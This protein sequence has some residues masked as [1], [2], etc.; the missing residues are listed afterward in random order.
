MGIFTI[1]GEL[2][3]NFTYTPFLFKV[4]VTNKA[5]YL[6]TPKI[7]DIIVPF[8]TDYT[9]YFGDGTDREGQKIKYEANEKSKSTLPPFITLE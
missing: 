5:P 8:D 7:P 3:N 4:N 6:Q 2:W 1:K 9:Y